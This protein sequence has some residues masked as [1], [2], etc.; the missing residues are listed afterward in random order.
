MNE[1]ES[2]WIFGLYRTVLYRIQRK[3]AVDPALRSVACN[4]E[5][6]IQ[7][8]LELPVR[9]TVNG[10]TSGELGLNVFFIIL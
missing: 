4:E 6:R 8:I 2:K 9:A 7:G 3:S 1:Q 10:R 5:H